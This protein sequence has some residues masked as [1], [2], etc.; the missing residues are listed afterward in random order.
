MPLPHPPTYQALWVGIRDLARLLERA[1]EQQATQAC[2][3][4]E[5]DSEGEFWPDLE[6]E[7]EGEDEAGEEADAL[8]SEDERC[9]LL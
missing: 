3:E 4:D 9:V 8:C 1:F 7:A 6:D 2:G 5:A